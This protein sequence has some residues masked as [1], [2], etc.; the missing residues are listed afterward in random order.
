MIKLSIKRNEL[1]INLEADELNEEETITVM[2][3]VAGI[4][5]VSESI[6]SK[7]GSSFAEFDAIVK[8]LTSSNE[9]GDSNE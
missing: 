3:G 9:E 7:D 1:E 5:T 8:A 2:A 6:K 4:I